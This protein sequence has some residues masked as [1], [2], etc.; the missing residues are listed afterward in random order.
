MT[1]VLAVS[2]TG[3]LVSLAAVFSSEI[4]VV[5]APFSGADLD[6]LPRFSEAGLIII[7]GLLAC[8]LV[9]CVFT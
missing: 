6:T 5:V 9:C 1:M 8:L 2:F 3:G 7:F 4:G